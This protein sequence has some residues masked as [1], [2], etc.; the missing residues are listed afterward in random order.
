MI[1]KTITEW[2]KFIKDMDSIWF[3]SIDL[4]EPGKPNTDTT[5][6]CVF[7]NGSVHEERNNIF[8]GKKH[9]SDFENDKREFIE[10]SPIQIIKSGYIE[11]Y[12]MNST[13]ALYS[14]FKFIDRESDKFSFYNFDR[15]PNAYPD[16]CACGGIM[17]TG[18]GV[19]GPL[20]FYYDT[21][22]VRVMVID[23]FCKLNTKLSKNIGRP[24]P[25]KKGIN[26]ARYL[27][28]VFETDVFR[29]LDKCFKDAIHCIDNLIIPKYG[30]YIDDGLRNFYPL[31]DHDPFMEN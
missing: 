17:I 19:Q 8:I 1:K 5:T 10:F 29:K 7:T 21:V 23:D 13:R 3:R 14:L 2:Y 30:E 12:D 9:I 22:E 15:D 27:K 24:L 20:T 25:F 4:I 28:I 31:I 11:L 26:N 16:I 6:Y 18:D